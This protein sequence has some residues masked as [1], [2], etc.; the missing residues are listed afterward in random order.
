MVGVVTVLLF[1][2]LRFM[3]V[4]VCSCVCLSGFAAPLHGKEGSGELRIQFEWNAIR[5]VLLFQV[6]NQECVHLVVLCF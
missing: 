1:K 3:F 2:C 5:Y 6:T 4:Y